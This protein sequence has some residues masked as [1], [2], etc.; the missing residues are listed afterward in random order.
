[1]IPSASMSNDAHPAEED[2]ITSAKKR[3]RFSIDIRYRGRRPHGCHARRRDG[4]RSA[5]ASDPPPSH[6]S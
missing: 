5:S 3:E 2:S 6:V 1:M 4:G